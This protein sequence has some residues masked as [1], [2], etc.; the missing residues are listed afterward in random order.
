MPTWNHTFVCLASTTQDTLPDAEQ[1]A[2]LQIADL[3][4][5]KITLPTSSDACEIYED[6]LYHFP[7]NPQAF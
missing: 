3:G 2:T 1:R 7:I 5:K 4:E 6:L